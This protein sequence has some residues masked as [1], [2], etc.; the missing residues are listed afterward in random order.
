MTSVQA[1][2]T[3]QSR[4]AMVDR[5]VREFT[6]GPH[7]DL[8]RP[9]VVCP[10]MVR[11]IARSRL[12]LLPF[13]AGDP[14]TADEALVARAHD[15]RARARRRAAGFA[16]AGTPGESAHLVYIAVPH[17]RPEHELRGLVERVHARLRHEFVASGFM[18]GDFWPDHATVGL[19]G[20]AF[21][22][23][24]SPVPVFALRHMVAADLPFFAV[25]EIPVEIRQ[26]FLDLYSAHFAGRLTDHWARRLADARLA[27]GL[28]AVA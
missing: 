28:P 4:V 9:G 7:P 18:V 2:G 26:E 1:D 22:P 17:G 25:P 21:R 16:A 14:E 6:T 15:F 12:T 11:S 19:H 23:F 3:V 13:D 20:P 8:G 5:W 24:A 10:Y 27:A